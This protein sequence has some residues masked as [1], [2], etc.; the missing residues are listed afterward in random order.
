MLQANENRAQ[1]LRNIQGKAQK[2]IKKTE[3]AQAKR[4][5]FQKEGGLA[6]NKATFNQAGSPFKLRGSMADRATNDV[7]NHQKS[8]SPVNVASNLEARFASFESNRAQQMD[9]T[10]QRA[11]KSQAK[12]GQAKKKQNQ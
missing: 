1:N 4:A 3:A 12:V 2:F 10:V 6:E 5:K 11:R 7:I 8:T 9:A